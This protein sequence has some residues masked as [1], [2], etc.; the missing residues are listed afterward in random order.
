MKDLREDCTI[1]EW[2]V[3]RDYLA[4]ILKIDQFSFI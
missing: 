2:Q 1:I 3:T 4:G